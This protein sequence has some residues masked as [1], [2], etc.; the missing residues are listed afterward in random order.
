MSS[1]LVQ[2]LDYFHPYQRDILLHRIVVTSKSREKM[3]I[4]S[5]YVDALVVY[6]LERATQ[7]LKGVT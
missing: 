3:Q 5:V 6:W 4:L 7:E 2:G 1:I